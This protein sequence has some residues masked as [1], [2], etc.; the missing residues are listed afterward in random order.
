MFFHL[1]YETL[2]LNSAQ[3][4]QVFGLFLLF[5][6]V[7]M[8]TLPLHT[9]SLTEYLL[10]CT[11][12]QINLGKNLQDSVRG[13]LNPILVSDVGPVLLGISTSVLVP[14]ICGCCQGEQGPPVN[15]RKF[16]LN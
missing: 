6:G 8:V 1:S 14:A 11:V 2:Q 9:M 12:E 3:S 16:L 10:T 7:L 13:L 4:F 5:L 15:G